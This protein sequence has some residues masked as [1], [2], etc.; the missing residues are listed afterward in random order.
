MDFDKSAYV[1]YHS[2]QTGFPCLSF[3]IIPD[4]DGSGDERLSQNN[5][6]TF[7]VTGT[8]APSAHLNTIHVI[9]LSRMTKFK[10]KK[11]EEEESDEDSESSSDEDEE[12]GGGGSGSSDSPLLQSAEIP[13][14]WGGINR[15]R[16]CQVASNILAASWCDSGETI[17]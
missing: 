2:A 15:I 17:S 14:P 8:Q 9:H 7:L 11:D 6:S 3:D 5:V 1:L 10:H 12:G 4:G 13:H 16:H